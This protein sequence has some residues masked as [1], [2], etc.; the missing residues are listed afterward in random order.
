MSKLSQKNNTEKNTELDINFQKSFEKISKLRKAIAPDV[1]L[2]FYAYYKQAT[3][4]NNF[5]LNSGIDIRNAFKF[6]AWMQLN[7]MTSE[8]AKKEYISLANSILNK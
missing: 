1:M 8:E 3:F 2:K 7:G 4:G 6:N 5:T